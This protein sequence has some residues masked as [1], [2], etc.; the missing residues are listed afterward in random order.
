M[1]RSEDMTQANQSDPVTGPLKILLGSADSE[2]S[3]RDI[4]RQLHISQ[5]TVV[6]RIQQARLIWD[7]TRRREF[8][9]DVMYA[10]LTLSAVIAA[11]SLAVIA[12]AHG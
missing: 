1:L 6:R 9:R 10:L 11:I 3:T 5:P 8:W 4:A 12:A 2:L 7:Q